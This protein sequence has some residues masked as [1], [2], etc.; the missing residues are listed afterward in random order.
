[1]AKSHWP[2]PAEAG[3]GTHD[4]DILEKSTR[5]RHARVVILELAKFARCHAVA[6][7]FITATIAERYLNSLKPYKSGA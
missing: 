5:P 2:G 3:L 4:L 1:M 7:P 6:V